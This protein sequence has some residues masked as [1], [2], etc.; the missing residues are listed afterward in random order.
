[1]KTLKKL[2]SLLLCLAMVLSFFPA[3]YA[4][5]EGSIAP[6]AED[7]EPA[8]L[9]EDEIPSVPEE[10]VGE[11]SLAD[12]DA[13]PNKPVADEPAATGS[14][15]CGPNLRWSLNSSGILTI[16]G[17]GDMNDYAK[18]N[19]A[20]WNQYSA[21][22][23]SIV[24]SNGVTGIG[25]LAFAFLLKAPDVSLPNSLKRIG[26]QAFLSSGVSSI[27]IPGSVSEI[28]ESAFSS[29]DSL[30]QVT[31]GEGVRSI[32]NFAFMNCPGLYYVSL[33][34]SLETI[35]VGAFYEDSYVSLTIPAGV[36]SIGKN[37]LFYSENTLPTTHTFLGAPY[38]D[39]AVFS[40]SATTKLYFLGG[41]P[42]FHTHAF[43]GA[44]IT[45]YYPA[46]DPAWTSDVRQQY[47][48]TVTWT[49]IQIYT[50]SYD[51]N[52]G[53]GAP[54]PQKKLQGDYIYLSYTQPNRAEETLG[55]VT[56]MLDPHGG[57]IS[58]S[59]E[60]GSLFATKTA[61]YS[62]RNWNT[63]ADGSG[64]SYN[65][66]AKY[67]ED[68]DLTL[69]A[70]W[71]QNVSTTKLT[72]PT[73]VREGY[74]FLG[75][76]EDPEASSG[77]TGS[78]TP[79]GD[80]TLYA[81]WRIKTYTVSYDANGGSGAP[82]AQVKTHD[83]DL[84][85]TATEPVRDGYSFLGWAR[86]S[87]ADTPDYQLGDIYAENADLTLYAV[88]KQMRFTVRYDAN[89]GTGAPASQTKTRGEDLILAD[90]VPTRSGYDFLGWGTAGTATVPAYQPGDSYTVNA[91]LTLYA[92]WTPK[93]YAVHYDANGGSGAPA[94][95]VKTYGVTLRLSSVKPTR[96]SETAEPYLITL[97]PNGGTVDTDSLTAENTITYSFKNWNTDQYGY[98]SS[99]S[100][101][102]NYTANASVTLYAQWTSSIA[103]QA[104]SLPT[105]TRANY[106]FKGWATSADASSGTTGSYKPGGNVTL[107]AIWAA[108]TYTV[109]YDANGGTG[110][111]A[112][113]TKKHGE[114]LIL[115]GTEPTRKDFLFL[116]WAT[117]KSA[118]IPVYQPSGLFQEN[119]DVTL[120]AVWMKDVPVVESGKCGDNITWTLYEDGE[121]WLVGTGPMPVGSNVMFYYPPYYYSLASQIKSVVI[122]DGITSIGTHAFYYCDSLTSVTIPDSV[123]SIGYEAFRGCS[124]L[125]A[126]SIPA[127]VASLGPGA[128][129][130]CRGLADTDGFVIVNDILFGYYGA[131]TSVSIPS[132]VKE[133]S[134]AA[135]AGNTNIKT[136]TIPWGV[137]AIGEKAFT[138]CSS[139]VRVSIPASVTG[140]DDEAF[141]DCAALTVASV[142][143]SVTSIGERAFYGCKGL[144]DA[145][146]FV[147]VNHILF[148]Y[149]G[150]ATSV[151]IPADVTSIGNSAF[152]NC[153]SL[154]GVT[155]P[156]G[157]TSIGD[158]AFSGC[159]SLTGVTIPN[160]V[161][162]IGNYA[163]YNCS[164]LTNVDIPEGVT[165]VGNST[166]YG[167]SGLTNM[168][169]PDGV[170]S[171]GNY[172]FYNCS[173]LTSVSL[174]ESVITIGDYSFYRCS[175]LTEVTIPEGVTNI[176]DDAFFCCSGLTNVT[177]PESLTRIGIEAF[178]NCSMLR[179]V[180][181]PVGVTVIGGSAFYNCRSLNAVYIHDLGA[182]CGIQFANGGANPLTSAKKLYLNGELAVN[183]VIP[184]G[185]T[186]IGN[187][188]FSNCS[189]L[190]SVTI[191]K[192]VTSVGDGAFSQC[193]ELSLV[194]YGGSAGQRE[195]IRIGSNNGYLQSASW[196]YRSRPVPFSLEQGEH[197]TISLVQAL[198]GE[199]LVGL[200][201]CPKPGYCLE[202]ITI[203]GT[204]ADK[205]T[206][207][208]GDEESLL[209]SARFVL[210]YPEKT[211]LKSG[212]CG[213]NMTWTLYED[214]LLDI[215]GSGAMFEYSSSSPRAPWYENRADITSIMIEPGVTFIGNY[216]FS[217]CS[218]L[219][220]VT[221][222][223]SVTGIGSAA[224]SSC[225]LLTAVYIH[226][227]GTW[228][229]IS[230]ENDVSNPLSFA[231]NLYIN[232]ELVTD[233]VIPESVNEIG[234][235]A[236][237]N[238]ACLTSAS[239]PSNTRIGVQAFRGCE[240]LAD[241][242]GFIIVNHILFGFVSK[243]KT[244]VTIPS[245]V[246]SIGER[247]FYECKG[248]KRVT[249]PTGVTSIGKYAFYNCSDLITVTIPSGMTSI[250]K[251]AFYNCRSLTSVTIPVGV[252]SIEYGTFQCCWSLTN[253][254]IPVGVT[255]IG[256]YA[257]EDCMS[258]RSV[259][260]PVGVTS[261]GGSAFDGCIKLTDVTI[262]VGV[263]SIGGSAF[264]NCSSLT[265]VTIPS[266]VKRIGHYTF[267]NCSSLTSVTIPTGLTSIEFSAFENCS[268]LTALTF[269]ESLKSVSSDAFKGC[270]AL[271]EIRFLGPAPGIYSSSFSGV[272]ANAYYHA[273]DTTWTADARANYGGTLTWVSY[274]GYKVRYD[275]NG[276]YGVPSTQIKQKGKTLTL[277]SEKPS[278]SAQAEDRSVTLDP[279]CVSLNGKTMSA[280]QKTSF[281][282]I[283][284]NTAA[285]GSGTT[286]QPGGSYT[287]NAELSLYA[288]WK[289]DSITT[290]SVTLPSYTREG[291]TFLGW[292]QDPYA[293]T[294]QYRAGARLTPDKAM[295]L[296]AVWAPDRFEVRYDANGGM[297]APAAQTKEYDFDLTLTTAVPKH[298]EASAGSYTVTLDPRGGG[299]DA[300]KLTAER[301]TSFTFRNWNTA[302]NGSGVSYAPGDSYIA[303]VSVTLYAQ[304]DA[305]TMTEAVSLPMPEREGYR[306]KGW[307][308]DPD[309]DDGLTGSF[310]PEDNVT[311]YA[312]WELAAVGDLRVIGVSGRPGSEILVPL[313]L[314]DNPGLVAINFNLSYDK[315]V[316][317]FV[318]V[319]DGSMTGW[320]RNLKRAYVFWEATDDEEKT[321]AGVIVML[322]FRIAEDAQDGITE[323]SIQDLEVTDRNDENLSFAA[324]AGE[325]TVSSR[326]PGDV[327]GD[328]LVDILDLIRLRKYLAQVNVEINSVNADLTGDG[329]VNADDLVRLRKYLVGDPTAVLD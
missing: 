170:T 29:C 134:R 20:P 73:P 259:T 11:I 305:V 315:S 279:N 177:L 264:Q 188:A 30:E 181:I 117:D 239:I 90:T 159:G 192:S 238:C 114:D 301:T 307:A 214:G 180:T 186:D 69:Y 245:G 268:S 172:A 129:M 28:G 153:S 145:N 53:S 122:G 319:E 99:Y 237:Y 78:Y 304:W 56:V 146:G 215:Q 205:D 133:V 148:G 3:A 227:I 225:N 329:L 63:R 176:G 266:G 91:D 2:L 51:A 12:P 137:T 27:T 113:Q 309:A 118:T 77:V 312:V 17:T 65:K 26:K 141:L 40:M 242:D 171:I 204:D 191:P 126:I 246:T 203:N 218:G 166:F 294:A 244:I 323:V 277:S 42:S 8:E 281:S 210:A 287:A 299:V 92:I 196:Y 217:G 313:E 120:Y 290:D 230:F 70:Q 258:L 296:Y 231:H 80:V 174:P 283:N 278:R 6:V 79:T 321:A 251:H 211:I 310:T 50:V 87:L 18:D 250:G 5:E 110:A 311:L 103:T 169:I 135:F 75:W 47:N 124:S 247:A 150:T 154:T 184:D 267:Y 31:I 295:T 206:F 130:G 256:N 109:R 106:V 248:L 270:T 286:Y 233:L 22:I 243:G 163:F 185:V 298:A 229:G 198:R 282:F 257:F 314:S 67:A 162:S 325:I 24:V 306:F 25:E 327:N 139:L 151:S 138:R 96:P 240:G 143:A 49:P 60:P 152:Y 199:K 254:T 189:D 300:E 197:G 1:M 208:V 88:W 318:G 14:G 222:P 95:Q 297:D 194:F 23:T 223:V 104:V 84:T 158:S 116:G 48:G 201:V 38:L 4:E 269:P 235:Y 16:S 125:P 39:Q 234:N 285:D 37:A 220:D 46:D 136:V 74:D 253:V 54:Q 13:A 83:V 66:G 108:K 273:D 178:Y 274:S 168:R 272:T 52:G 320:G 202:S 89:G 9:G 261:I 164:S 101:G 200:T 265:S 212:V 219:T 71:T 284:W 276:G 255:E 292:A 45:A 19:Y 228:C 173:S 144:A 43:F 107:Y 182:W 115:A 324:I 260:I 226:D 216:A 131:E 317:E 263:T 76:A 271:T 207:I 155:I 232:G 328:G 102:G 293:A 72:L 123:T 275:G 59:E 195:R 94:D 121:L 179:D 21:S 100:A 149:Y 167:C 10:P 140:I 85:L 326:L 64:T 302:Q 303:N 55:Q 132:G 165:S 280:A 98:G 35:G 128:F 58:G 209:I 190:M 119:R 32:G 241:S 193:N 62:F 249:I 308:V 213:E 142:P 34:E 15:T 57:S 316:L 7:G 68:A 82:E 252:T 175:S 93:T 112:S 187:Y 61:I 41:V 236:F 288:Q 183:A 33:P 291:Y 86:S 289:T 160:G 97:D 161:T 224:F 221:I 322:R 36:K 81:L 156:E 157:V 127:G 105:P 111:P 262:P 44:T 147:V